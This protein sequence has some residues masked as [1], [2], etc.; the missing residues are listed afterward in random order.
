MMEVQ[1]KDCIEYA[2]HAYDTFWDYYKRTLDER[3]Q[4]LNN[5]IIVVGI[6]ISLIGITIE[7]LKDDISYYLD[8]IVLAF[9]VVLIF[10]I[11]IYN[12]YIVESFISERYLKKIEHITEYLMQHYDENYRGV[13]SEAYSLDKIFLDKNESQKHKLRKGFLVIIINTIIIIGIIY[14][15]FLKQKIKYYIFWGVL[16]SLFVHMVIFVYHWRKG[17]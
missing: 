2:L 4:I 1:E 16:V 8:W 14:L 15:K 9:V 17:I 7:R 5:Y 6:P 10:G 11:V 13:F 3:N 12:A